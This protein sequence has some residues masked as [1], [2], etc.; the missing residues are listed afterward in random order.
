MCSRLI[1]ALPLALLLLVLF[2]GI[3]IVTVEGDTRIRIRE[4]GIP[5]DSST[6]RSLRLYSRVPPG[7]YIVLGED[8]PVSQD[9]RHF[10]FVP[11]ASLR[12]KVIGCRFYG[13]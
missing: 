12:G 3:T 13:R 6:Y 7:Y 1:L 10:G 8:K 9:S 4:H 2:Y 5:L 11:R